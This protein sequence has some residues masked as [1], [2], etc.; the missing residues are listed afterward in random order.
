[1]GSCL[2]IL[3]KTKSTNRRKTKDR[4]ILSNTMAGYQDKTLAANNLT[5]LN[6]KREFHDEKQTTYWLPKDDEEQRRLTGV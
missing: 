1:M 2:S 4:N 5:N 6:T 3:Q